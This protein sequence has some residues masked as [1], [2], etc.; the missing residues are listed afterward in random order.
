[1]KADLTRFTDDM[2][3]TA[4]E[5]IYAALEATRQ[6][7]DSPAWDVAQTAIDALDQ[8]HR[9][10]AIIPPRL[11]DLFNALCHHY[12]PNRKLFSAPHRRKVAMILST[13]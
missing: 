4:E 6:P 5:I 13:Y 8:A 2:D 3:L 1:M 10:G 12:H 7:E 11:Y 9:C